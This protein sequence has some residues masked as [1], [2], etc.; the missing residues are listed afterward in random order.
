MQNASQILTDQQSW[1]NGE[2]ISEEI[3]NGCHYDFSADIKDWKSSKDSDSSEF[4]SKSHNLASKT[5]LFV[6]QKFSNFTLVHNNKLL[7]LIPK[8]LLLFS[9]FY[10]R[11]F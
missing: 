5:W 3:L 1:T 4:R 11:H 10:N 9:F 2:N 6:Q 7:I 8:N